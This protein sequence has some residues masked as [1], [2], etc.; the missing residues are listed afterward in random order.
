MTLA[1]FSNFSTTVARDP[2]CLSGV[3]LTI[4]LPMI[5]QLTISSICFFSPSGSRNIQ[6]FKKVS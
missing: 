1:K 2:R 5:F 4:F 6:E 3:A